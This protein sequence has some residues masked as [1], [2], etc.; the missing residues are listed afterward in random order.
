MIGLRE[1]SSHFFWFLLILII[2]NIASGALCYCIGA[3]AP[4]VGSGNLSSILLILGNMLM[5]GFIL[6]IESLPVYLSWIKYFSYFGY[7]YEAL[8]INELHGKL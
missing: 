3:I 5:A 7:A 4:N 2:F 1:I 6:N 8:L